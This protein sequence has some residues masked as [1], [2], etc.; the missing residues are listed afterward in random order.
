MKWLLTFNDMATL[1]LTFFVLIISMSHID[2]GKVKGI[3]VSARETLG[4]TEATVKGESGVIEPF[5]LPFRDADIEKER[6]KVDS[7]GVAGGAQ[8]IK[9]A[10]IRSLNRLKGVRVF[11]LKEGLSLSLEE[12]LL[13]ASGSADILGKARPLLKALGG[14]IHKADVLV[15]VEGNTD[16]L[17]I[18]TG[19]FPSNWELSTARAVAV[20]KYLSSEGGVAPG[21]LSVAGYADARPR[22]PNVNPYNRQLNRRVEI[23][24]TFP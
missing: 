18:M 16:N 17:P 15:R 19:Q 12:T 1:L 11:P 10:F 2:A 23:I 4:P 22:V 5:L 6:A 13:F 21:R 7:K 9:E 3:S 14:I 24:L 8:N 20:V